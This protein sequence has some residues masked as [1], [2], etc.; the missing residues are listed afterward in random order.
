MADQELQELTQVSEAQI[1]ADDLF[2]LVHDPAGTPTP[3]NA[4]VGSLFGVM[5]VIT[6]SVASNNLTVALKHL[7]GTDPSATKPL[8][9]KIGDAWQLVVAAL[10]TTKN[11]ATNWCDAGGAECAAKDEFV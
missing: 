3:L 11:A 10:S 8:V 2:Y 4:P 9:F 5:Y 1:S 7:D 6:P